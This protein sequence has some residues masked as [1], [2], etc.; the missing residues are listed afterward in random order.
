[1]WCGTDTK[2]ISLAVTTFPC[3]LSYLILRL[4]NGVIIL[5]STATDSSFYT[6]YFLLGSYLSAR[7]HSN[8][9]CMV[10]SVLCKMCKIYILVHIHERKKVAIYQEGPMAVDERMMTSLVRRRIRYDNRQGK[11][12][13]AKDIIFVYVPHHMTWN[14]LGS[15]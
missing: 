10:H 2:I 1:M 14:Y 15:W 6:F 5:S 3:L 11:I 13:T 7:C 4:T 9:E 12:V 8:L